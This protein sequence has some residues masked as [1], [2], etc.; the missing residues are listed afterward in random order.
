[1]F[2]LIIYGIIIL[3]GFI[4]FQKDPITTSIIVGIILI[5]YL[6]P[7]YRKYKNSGEGIFR[8]GEIGE[9]TNNDLVKLVLLMSLLNQNQS[10]PVKLIL[11]QDV[12]NSLKERDEDLKEEKNQILKLFDN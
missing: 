2:K 5:I 12:M 1:M 10:Q 11:K 4:F 8:K 6:Y 3:L 9:S 7:K